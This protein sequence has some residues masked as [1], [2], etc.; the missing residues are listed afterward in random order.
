[1]KQTTRVRQLTQIPLLCQSTNPYLSYPLISSSTWYSRKEG[2]E[3][4]KKK[5]WGTKSHTKKDLLGS[6][7]LSFENKTSHLIFRSL[8]YSFSLSILLFFSKNSP[9]LLLRITLI[10][11]SIITQSLFFFVTQEESHLLS[12]SICLFIPVI[13]AIEEMIL[14]SSVSLKKRIKEEKRGDPFLSFSSF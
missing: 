10:S 4:R 14:M 3:N 7:C 8:K 1:M 6:F 5:E 12:L 11:S 9:L 2:R 13:W